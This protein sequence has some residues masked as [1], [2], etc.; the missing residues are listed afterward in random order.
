MLIRQAA[1]IGAGTMGAAIAAHLA[2]AGMRTLLLDIVP[3][4]LNKAEEKKDLSLTDTA[5]RNRIATN[6]IAA[7][8]KARPAPLYDIQDAVLLTAGNLEDNFSDLKECDWIIEAVT[9][10]LDI[11]RSLFSRLSDQHHAGQIVSSNTS[12]IAL[13][14]ILEGMP[15]SFCSHVC[16]THFFNPPRYMHLMEMVS[17]ELTDAKI[18][19]DMQE[20][21]ERVLGKGVVVAKDTA[22]FIAN[23]IGAYDI[24]KA[25]SL[26]IELGLNTETVDAIAGPLLGRPKSAVFRL[27]DMVGIDIMDHVNH[28]LYENVTDDEEHAIFQT[29]DLCRYMIDNKILGDKTKGG[30]YK[31]TKDENGKRVIQVFDWQSHEYRTAEKVESETLLAAKKST[32][33]TE[34]LRGLVEADDNIGRFCWQLLSGTL[35][36][37]ARRIPEIADN[38]LAIDRAMKWGYN[39]K[40]GPFELWDLLGVS[41]VAERLQKEGREIPIFV[42]QLLDSSH[43][44]FY[45]V[46]NAQ[47]QY[48][49]GS[50]M[51][52]LPTIGQQIY[53]PHVKLSSTAIIE[54][55]ATAS[56]IDIGD[57]ILA[58][59]FHGKANSLSS[60]T[61]ATMRRAIEIA[62]TDF[63]AMVVGNHGTHFS[64]GA[65]LMELAGFAQSGDWQTVDQMIA[66]FQLSTSALKFSR[67]PVVAAIHGMVLGGGCETAMHCAQRVAAPEL[68]MGLVEAGVGL[69]PAAGGCKEWA[70]RASQHGAG[71]TAAIFPE[72]NRIL[73]MLAMAKTTQNA[74]D[75]RSMG[76]MHG[77]DSMSRN[78]DAIMYHAKHQA[79]GL[80]AMG[81]R[82]PTPDTH[83]SVLGR[84]GIAEFQARLHMW[85]EGGY[86]SAHDVVVA[87]KIAHVLCGGN[88]SSHLKVSEQ[89]L[90]ELERE[91]FL[92]LAGEEKTQE[93]IAFTLKTGKPLRN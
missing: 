11:K 8:A 4:A 54:K 73:E 71:D 68:Y 34:S 85:L 15:Q 44:S 62:E 83:I 82:P 5:V 89:Y 14:D 27:F 56:C 29:P 67:V 10:R 69:L 87:T 47:P 17:G 42:Q 53:L 65:D 61:L 12:G 48:F 9:E 24:S 16:I 46:D 30:F 70:L 74:V 26:A 49:D 20:F 19:A 58:L 25:L 28:N 81:Y 55:S 78:K 32:S 45:A 52:I 7:M 18:F 76:Y 90:L 84:G 33:A 2:N 40:H 39:W 66:N 63:Q 3:H 23:R 80:A 38:I 75:A 72:L 43:D 37:S 77:G 57:G 50:A 51:C 64:V 13:A 79:L 41:Y 21:I 86:M 88:V 60:D 22:N 31:K 36:Y 1:V 93:R 35:C 59:E 91:A 6:A 92:S